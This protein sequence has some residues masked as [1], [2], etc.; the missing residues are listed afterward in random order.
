[1]GAPCSAPIQGC[2]DSKGGHP[3]SP[4]GHWLCRVSL[5]LPRFRRRLRGSA[6]PFVYR[7]PGL[8]ARATCRVR[9]RGRTAGS[10]DPI[11]WIVRVQRAASGGRGLRRNPKRRRAAALD[12]RGARG[13]KSRG[14]VKRAKQHPGACSAGNQSADVSAHSKPGTPVRPIVRHRSDSVSHGFNPPNSRAAIRLPAGGEDI[15]RWPGRA[16]QGRP[17][18]PESWTFFDTRALTGREDHAER[19]IALKPSTKVRRRA[20]IER[21]VRKHTAFAKRGPLDLHDLSDAALP[22]P[23]PGRG[24][25]L[26][27]PVSRWPRPALSGPALPRGTRG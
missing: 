6:R 13:V 4:K 18:P 14:T 3:F 12:G 15:S 16:R 8:A 17:Q 26:G 9:W 23:A 19:P 2:A 11:P 10:I 22:A 24:R 7:H 21:A 25:R 27:G 20:F 1:M 5:A